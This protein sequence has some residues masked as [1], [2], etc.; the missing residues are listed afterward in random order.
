MH[1]ELC[2]FEVALGSCISLECMRLSVLVR[3]C[4]W[5]DVNVDRYI[6]V[7]SSQAQPHSPSLHMHSHIAPAPTSTAT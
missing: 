4:T 5:E 1:M 3:G 7:G 2:S 6:D